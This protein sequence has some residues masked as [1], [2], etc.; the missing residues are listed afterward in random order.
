MTMGSGM[1]MMTGETS[2]GCGEGRSGEAAFVGSFG[3]ARICF[4]SCPWEA[5]V[6]MLGC[7]LLS[8][9]QAG[10]RQILTGL[11]LAFHVLN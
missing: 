7:L 5:A 11:S 1:H 2:Q 10:R 8:R 4:F 3:W 9:W 6:W